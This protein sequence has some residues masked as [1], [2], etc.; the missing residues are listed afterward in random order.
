MKFFNNSKLK[1]RNYK[2]TVISELK[3]DKQSLDVIAN[4]SKYVSDSMINAQI[5]TDFQNFP[6][7][8]RLKFEIFC[9][10]M[11]ENRIKNYYSRMLSNLSS[12]LS[13]DYFDCLSLYH[14]NIVMV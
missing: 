2:I 1:K 9:N 13:K 8:Y 6:A 14:Y 12:W 3:K 10:N 11:T 7:G 4:I 5:I